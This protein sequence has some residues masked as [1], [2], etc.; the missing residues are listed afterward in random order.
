MGPVP[1]LSVA[2]RVH[3]LPGASDRVG[4]WDTSRHPVPQE[5]DHQRVYQHVFQQFLINYQDFY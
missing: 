2:A 1:A 3:Q 4:D 5:Q